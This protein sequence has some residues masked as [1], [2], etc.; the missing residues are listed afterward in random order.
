MGKAM[1]KQS[2]FNNS[3]VDLEDL[4]NG[5]YFV[6]IENKEESTTIRVIKH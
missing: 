5:V 4:A 2:A 1:L 6:K 3:W